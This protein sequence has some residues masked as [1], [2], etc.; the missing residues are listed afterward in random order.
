MARASVGRAKPGEQHKPWADALRIGAHERDGKGRPK[1]RVIADKTIQMAMD[2]DM[3]AIKEIGNRLDGKPKER[4]EHDAG[5]GMT[6][7]TLELIAAIK[8]RTN[9]P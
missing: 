6:A 4:M 1:L 3:E 5:P 8:A 7:I 9:A 2:G